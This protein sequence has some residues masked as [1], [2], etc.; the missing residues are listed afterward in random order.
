MCTL[1][2]VISDDVRKGGT[3][4]N[5]A[6]RCVLHR[7][8]THVPLSQPPSK[9][10]K[11][12]S[13]QSTVKI[14]PRL[15]ADVSIIPNTRPVQSETSLGRL[16]LAARGYCIGSS[17]VIG[18][19]R[20]L[21]SLRGRSKETWPCQRGKVAPSSGRMRSLQVCYCSCSQNFLL[22]D[23][24]LLQSTG[25]IT[26]ERR[27]EVKVLLFFIHITCISLIFT[28]S[29]IFLYYIFSL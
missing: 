21:L 3:F 28:L 13:L 6:S 18:R 29:F 19:P 11:K 7:K 25:E 10:K 5:V 20:C 15:K 1:P 24:I 4:P 14:W 23:R 17:D 26:F 22:H 16:P 2:E 27:R 12:S 9:K 8:I